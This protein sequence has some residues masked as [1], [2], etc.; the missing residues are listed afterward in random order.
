MVKINKYPDYYEAVFKN[1]NLYAFS[2]SELK[3]QLHDI[4]GLNIEPFYLE[5]N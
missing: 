4:Y 1:G 5:C 3:T 2:L